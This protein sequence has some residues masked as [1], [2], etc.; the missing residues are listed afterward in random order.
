MKEKSPQEE[1]AAIRQV[2][3]INEALANAKGNG[4]V[5]L[6]HAGMP[7][8]RIYPKG[9]TV[10]PFNALVLQLFADRNDYPSA[11]YVFFH[12]AKATDIPVLGKEKG[13]P[14]NWYA[15][16]NYVNR[17]DPKDVITASDYKKL[18]PERQ[19]EYKGVQQRQI[20]VLFNLAQT[21]MP[22]SDADKYR[23]VLDRYGSSN[24]RGHL[25]AEERQLRATVNGFIKQMKDYLVPI[26]RE[27]SDVAHYD[28]EKDAV[29]MPEQRKYGEY[30][31]YVQELMR[32]IVNAT[33]H[34][35]R[36]ARE[37]MVMKGGRAPGDYA[38]RYEKLVVEVASAVKMSELGLPARLSPQNIGLVDAWTRELQENPCMIDA[39]E[40]D[41]NNALDVI[42]KAEQGEK[43]EYARFRTQAKIDELQQ[44]Q[45]PQVDSHEAVILCDILRHNGMKI[46]DRNFSTPEEKR[47]FLDKFDLTYYNKELEE[48][49]ALTCSDDPEQ[50]ELAYGEALKNADSINRLCFEYLPTVWN[51]R[52]SHYLIQD[53]I[54]RIPCE[55]DRSMAVV[56]DI[57]TGIYDVV[58]PGGA[59][60]GGYVNLPDGQRRLFRVTPDEVMSSKERADARAT[61]TNFALKG[62]PLSRIESAMKKDG[63]TYVRFYNNDGRLSLGAD[64]GFYEGRTVHE[65]AYKGG[66]LSEVA[67][68]DVSGAVDA[69]N[70]VLFDRVHMLK[71][72]NARWAFY[73]KPR[74]SE[75]F[76]IYPEKED[77]NR[78]F[79]TLRQG[80]QSEAY[81]LRMELGQKY[82]EIIKVNPSLR[83]NIFNDIPEG[84]DVSRITRVNVYKTKEDKIMCA[85]RIEGVENVNPREITRDQWNRMFVAEDMDGYK[86]SLAA[87]VFADVLG[88]R[89]SQGEAVTPEATTPE[90]MVGRVDVERREDVEEAQTVH[91]GR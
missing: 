52:S 3:L 4:G 38:D 14:F 82:Y 54:R 22:H 53:M 81:R 85:P 71:D 75:S 13:V 64:D 83:F 80:H 73:I 19:K 47:E 61:L 42:R 39:L 72:D 28:T 33:G 24:E 58:L 34:Q 43:I 16:D 59:M 31:E 49:M 55:A 48:A 9:P 60:A 51:A 50:V 46:D 8:P 2:Q 20:R 84:V 30:P 35:Q 29:Y 62:F 63:A 44:K 25:R 91:R 6:N 37:G 1:K 32:Q 5:W 10:S 21:V 26:R 74:D 69:A 78:F 41:V 18:A 68:L 76:C 86:T 40:A 36:L 79:S 17:H 88:A 12:T 66:R 56:K 67:R 23:T 11:Q 27:A 45:K 87:K 90:P 77:V 89:V 57:R 7:A 15:W 70:S 65:M